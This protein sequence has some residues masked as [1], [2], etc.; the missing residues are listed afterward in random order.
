MVLELVSMWVRLEPSSPGLI[1]S[2][3]STIIGQVFSE[4]Q[5]AVDMVLAA[6]RILDCKVSVLV[7][8]AFGPVFEF[9]QCR[10]GPPIVETAVGVEEATLVVK[11]ML[12]R[13][14]LTKSIG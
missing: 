4:S 2:L 7:D 5:L 3:Q 1:R 13:S 14:K 6:L 10:V 9:F 12:L 11:C 8:K